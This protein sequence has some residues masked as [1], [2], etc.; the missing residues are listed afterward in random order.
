M[1]AWRRILLRAFGAEIGDQVHIYNSAEIYFPWNLKVG[2][3]SAIGENAR[4]YNLGAVTIGKN[5]TISQYA[6]VCA[7]TH[8]FTDPTHEFT[9]P[10]RPLHKLPILIGDNAWVAA[11]AFVGPGVIVGENA[12]IGARAVVMKDV[13]NNC[14]VAGNPARRIGERSVG[15][16][17][18]RSGL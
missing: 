8:D 7:G 4:I 1:F 17:T 3:W 13:P 10:T 9:D 12:V 14:V 5:V 18:G 11:D 15:E 6:H 2:D 16:S